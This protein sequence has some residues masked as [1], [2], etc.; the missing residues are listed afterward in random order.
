M[1]FP[2]TFNAKTQSDAEFSYSAASMVPVG[3]ETPEGAVGFIKME[4]VGGP[5][6]VEV[7]SKFA[8]NTHNRQ[9][10]RT[11]ALNIWTI[12]RCILKFVSG[13]DMLHT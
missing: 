7:A 2:L 6:M 1:S 8:N 9:I 10:E 3:K 4:A 5:S 13:N 12:H 11:K